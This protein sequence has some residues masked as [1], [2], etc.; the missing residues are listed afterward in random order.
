MGEW[1]DVGTH[2]VIEA[3]KG[4]TPYGD[5]ENG[6]GYSTWEYGFNYRAQDAMALRVVDDDG[7]I[8]TEAELQSVVDWAKS[9]LTGGVDGYPI[10]PTYDQNWLGQKEVYGSKYHCSE[11]IWAAYQAALGIEL[12][13]D[14]SPFNINVA[15]DD[16]W[17][18]QYTSV[19]ACEIGDGTDGSI[20]WYNAA[21]TISAVYLEVPWIYYYDD[22]DGFGQGVGEMYLETYV[23]QY[24]EFDGYG[25][26]LGDHG[27][28]YLATG[29]AADEDLDQAV[30]GW[31]AEYGFFAQLDAAKI[32]SG[33]Y[34]LRD[35]DYYNDYPLIK[36]TALI[37]N[38]C[39]LRLQVR[40][41]ENDPFGQDYYPAW[42]DTQSPSEWNDRIGE[43]EYGV[44]SNNGDCYYHIHYSI[45]AAY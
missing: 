10:G 17:L 42:V 22:Y 2:Y 27:P 40:A 35:W 39:T 36:T 45:S 8:L 18:S 33:E 19:L 28:G 25:E 7:T 44:N 6:L 29:T 1:M 15:P 16:L 21:D 9:R 31:Q 3:T 14:M 43:G 32:G 12:D 34:W 4:T 20:E 38:D 23:G 26:V 30:I 5:L 41:K 37:N 24:W 13:A 11:L